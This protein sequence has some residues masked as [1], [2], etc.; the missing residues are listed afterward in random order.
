MSLQKLQVVGLVSLSVFIVT[1]FNPLNLVRVH[2]E[3]VLSGFVVQLE[4]SEVRQGVPIVLIAANVSVSA[5]LLL[6]V[7]NMD[8][9]FQKFIA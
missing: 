5:L 2:A 3:S 4:L 9:V 8:F 7:L 1:G 6:L